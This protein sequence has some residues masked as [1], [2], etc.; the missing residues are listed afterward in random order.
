[1]TTIWRWFK[2]LFTFDPVWFE[3]LDPRFCAPPEIDL[4]SRT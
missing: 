2:I 4:G 3:G 1:M